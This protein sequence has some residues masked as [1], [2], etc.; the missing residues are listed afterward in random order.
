MSESQTAKRLSRPDLRVNPNKWSGAQNRN[1]ATRVAI[2]AT[3]TAVIG[4]ISFV[5]FYPYFNIERFRRFL[6]KKN[7]IGGFAF[8]RLGQIQKVNRAGI[9][10]ADV[11]PAGN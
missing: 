4:G 5:F 6:M 2:L 10:Q 3:I 9:N 8:F 7:F 1:V 11:Q